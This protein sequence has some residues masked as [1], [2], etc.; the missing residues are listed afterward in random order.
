MCF[1]CAEKASEWTPRAEPERTPTFLLCDSASTR[2]I[3]PFK[4]PFLSLEAA[5][6]PHRRDRKEN[7]HPDGHTVPA[8]P[9]PGSKQEDLGRKMG[10]RVWGSPARS[11]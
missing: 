2:R 6:V 5:A 8:Q 4:Y 11:K 9:P 1:L 3:P 10:L 7:T